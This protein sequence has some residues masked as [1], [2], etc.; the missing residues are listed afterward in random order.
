[1]AQGFDALMSSKK[2]SASPPHGPPSLAEAAEI[3]SLQRK[4]KKARPNHLTGNTP[5][6]QQSR[7]AKSRLSQSIDESAFATPAP[8]SSHSKPP[9]SSQKLKRPTLKNQPMHR[10]S[11]EADL[12]TD[13]SRTQSLRSGRPSSRSEANSP[14]KRL[15]NTSRPSLGDSFP[16][17]ASTTPPTVDDD[18]ELFDQAMPTPEEISQRRPTPLDTL[19]A[20]DA[21][22]PSPSLSPITAAANLHNAGLGLQGME[23]E[24]DGYDV[25]SLDI[26]QDNQW[27]R[28]RRDAQGRKQPRL[29]I[30]A[31]ALA[32]Q[33]NNPQLPTPT[34][35]DLPYMLDSFDAMPTELQT[36]IMYQ[37]LRRC[38]KSTL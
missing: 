34:L 6:V 18:F 25:S 22:L 37:M 26:A 19:A 14:Q 23:G 8:D 33:S 13:N 30:G 29:D 2:R 1:M 10:V 11:G 3:A 21:S 36:Y 17:A 7:F 27:I 16:P 35:M 28:R 9:K 38:N 20:Q 5:P 4:H 31:A 15:E 24:D 12:S 32:D